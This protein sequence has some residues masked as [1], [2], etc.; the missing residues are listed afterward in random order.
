MGA[1][2]VATLFRIV[3]VTRAMIAGIAMQKFTCLTR[4]NISAS[5]TSVR[6]TRSRIGRLKRMTSFQFSPMF[7]RLNAPE[8]AFSIVGLWSV[9][10]QENS[11]CALLCSNLSLLKFFVIS[12]HYRAWNCLAGLPKEV[13]LDLFG[14]IQFTPAASCCHKLAIRN[15][16]WQQE[17]TA[18]CIDYRWV[19]G[20]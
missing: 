8:F 1:S 2:H 15:A 4:K 11:R 3:D 16:R 14:G 18:F 17:V 12:I 10:C 19:A 6:K 7:S 5:E 9:P 20:W 13:G